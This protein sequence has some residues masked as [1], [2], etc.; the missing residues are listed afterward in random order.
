MIAIGHLFDCAPNWEQR[1]G[2]AQLAGRL[3][4]DRFDCRV[5]ATCAD[6]TCVLASAGKP[7]QRLHCLPGSSVLAAPIV[8][9]W[10]AQ[11]NIDLVHTWRISAALAA[12]TATSLPL[13]L[14][15]SDPALPARDLKVLRTLCR[16]RHF[17]IACTSETVW[18]RLI[19]GGVPSDNC[20]VIRPGVDFSHVNRI[21][22][23][24]LR[25]Q[26]GLAQNAIAII[27][28]EP[29][30]P[31]G[32]QMDVV[33][34]VVLAGYTIDNL[35]MIVPGRSR[36]RARIRRFA[37]RAYAPPTLICPGNDVPFES[38]VAVADVL[39]IA[40]AGDVPSTSIA[41]AMAS[42]TTII[43]SA[44]HSVAEMIANK[45]NGLLFKRLANER[46]SAVIARLLSD[47]P[48][49]ATL[50]EAARGQAFEVFGVRRCMEQHM[51]LYENVLV[52]APPGEGITD[53]AVLA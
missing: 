18:R 21:R 43:A 46:P 41:W 38:L 30:S 23:S 8:G 12:R 45:V 14:A 9:R 25:A 5:A 29:I 39:I 44:V 47:G 40:A 28:A 36:E 10:V 20:V 11:Q 26:L 35:C 1:V 50:R 7:V 24:P 16:S 17:A 6:G 4:A 15:L 48:A 34:G 37:A 13:V 33:L 51:R 27:V 49:Q 42:D 31:A 2:L 53:T 22:R 52:G 19:E 3:P 32:G